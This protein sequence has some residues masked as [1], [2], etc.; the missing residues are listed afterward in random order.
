M[1]PDL[2]KHPHPDPPPLVEEGE[3]D[4]NEAEQDAIPVNLCIAKQRNGPIGEVK[5]TFLKNYTRFESAAK[6]EPEDNPGNS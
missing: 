1:V 5:L 3:N 2:R 4:A 6:I